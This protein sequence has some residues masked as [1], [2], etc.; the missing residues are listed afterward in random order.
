M[1]ETRVPELHD[2]CYSTGLSVFTYGMFSK[3]KKKVQDERLRA[4]ALSFNVSFLE[5]P[6][7]YPR[8]PYIARNLCPCRRFALLTV[9]VYLNWFSRNYFLKSHGVSQSNR[10]ENSIQREIAVQGHSRSCIL[11]SLKSRR[12]TA[13]RHI[14]MLASSLKYPKK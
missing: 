12:R 4:T 5:D 14:I 9:C 10:R 13:Y 7:E 6:T 1:P 2:S 11:G 8:K 3:A